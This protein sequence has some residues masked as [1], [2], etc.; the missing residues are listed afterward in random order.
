MASVHHV[1][2]FAFDHSPIEYEKALHAA[3]S[4]EALYNAYFDRQY[5]LFHFLAPQV[6]GHFDLIRI[7]DPDYDRHF[8][9]PSVWERIERNLAFMQQ[10]HAIL[11]FNL[12]AFAKGA[13]EPY[14]SAPILKRCLELGIKV[15][16]GEDAHKP[17]DCGQFIDQGLAVLKK[18]GIEGPFDPPG[19]FEPSV[20]GEDGDT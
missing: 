13:K 14:I 5:E 16:P 15:V 17:E 1:K 2:G 19:P 8:Q 10:H 4:P 6:V 7:F 3:G 18:I 20:F 11:D 9:I 12:R